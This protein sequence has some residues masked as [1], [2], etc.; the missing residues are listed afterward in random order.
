MEP[1]PPANVRLITPDDTEIPLECRYDGQDETGIHQWVAV[2][3]ADV[4]IR[5]GMSLRADMMPA[6]SSITLGCEM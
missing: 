2:S 4:V 3:P 1:T 6:R 5:P